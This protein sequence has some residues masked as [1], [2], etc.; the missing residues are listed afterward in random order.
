[1]VVG[2]AMVG[3][4]F[5]YRRP[6]NVISSTYVTLSKFVRRVPI[7]ER[8]GRIEP[9]ILTGPQRYVRNPLYF[10]VIVIVLGWGLLTASTFVL[11]T[12]VL[13]LLWFRFVL[14]PFE[15][16]ELCALFGDRYRK[17]MDETPALVP[18]SKRRQQAS[19]RWRSDLSD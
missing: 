9:L 14:I 2:L 13:L 15:E 5:R 18:F 16:R 7:A 11:L 12:A 17:Y 10:G 1:V 6:A 3:W 4:V 8:A 19:S